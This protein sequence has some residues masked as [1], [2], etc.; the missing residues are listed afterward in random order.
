VLSRRRARV[1]SLFPRGL[2]AAQS[3]AAGRS[4]GLPDHQYPDGQ[5]DYYRFYL[6]HFDQTVA[7]FDADIPATLSVIYRRGD[8]EIVGKV[9][10]SALVTRNGRWFG[11]AHRAPPI[12]PDATL[13]P[14]A[15]F[16]A[17]VEA[18]R[19]TG[20]RPG[21]SWYL[22][23]AA[24]IAYAHSAPDGGRL[25]QPVLFINGEFD[26]ICDI[27]RTQLGDPMRSAC[28]DLS[29]ASLP[30]GHWLPLEC[31]TELSHAI[32]SWLTTKKL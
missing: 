22:N 9:Y 5:W 20:F 6:S 14:S 1:C 27:T 26:S 3:P 21:N 28:L 16:N 24:N 15:D 25:R 30:A 4:R 23:D 8:P 7:D 17:L 12:P 2:R 19:L 10:L 31:R 11:S 32:E 18:F 29:I 13:W